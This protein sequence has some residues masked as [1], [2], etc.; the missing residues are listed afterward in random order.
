[1]IREVI[2]DFFSKQHGRLVTPAAS[3]VTQRVA[4][5]TNHHQRNVQVFHKLDTFTE[6]ISHKHASQTNLQILVSL[7][8]FSFTVPHA[9]FHHKLEG[10]S[11]ERI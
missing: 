11:V 6:N 8:L 1:M 3:D 9:T 4:A 7:T 5:A 2:A 10:H